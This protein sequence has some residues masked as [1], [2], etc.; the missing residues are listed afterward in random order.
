MI[1]TGFM[2]IGMD[3]VCGEYEDAVFVRTFWSCGKEVIKNLE[4]DR[5]KKIKKIYLCLTLRCA[6]CVHALV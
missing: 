4:S 2:Y 1:R 5:V 6:L 3:G